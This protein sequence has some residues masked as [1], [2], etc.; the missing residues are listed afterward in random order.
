MGER[1]R[2]LP[3]IVHRLAEREV[4]MKPVVVG[5]PG[6]A[7]RRIHRRNVALVETYRL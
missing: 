4:E 3:R 2:D 1:V 5:K 7:E 6:G